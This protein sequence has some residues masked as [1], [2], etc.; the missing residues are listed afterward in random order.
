VLRIEKRIRAGN[1]QLEGMRHD[2]EERKRRVLKYRER[3]DM[4][5]ATALARPT[6][7]M[8]AIRKRDIQKHANLVTL[9]D[10]LK[11]AQRNVNTAN[12]LK[13]GSMT[14]GEMLKNTPDVE[15]VLDNIREQIETTE[16]ISIE[17]AE[18]VYTMQYDDDEI[19]D[20]L[21]ETALPMPDAPTAPTAPLNKKVAILE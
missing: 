16:D 11:E 8:I 7:Q 10:T 13:A 3:G 12:L 19:L 6:M 1:L 17:L 15:S 21:L 14:L 9:L 2:I 5:M 18:P 20:A 4:E